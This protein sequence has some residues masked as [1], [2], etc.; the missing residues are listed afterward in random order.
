MD[1]LLN[2]TTNR[3]TDSRAIICRVV[4]NS[5]SRSTFFHLNN[6]ELKN[7]NPLFVDRTLRVT[8]YTNCF[9][10]PSNPEEQCEELILV[11]RTVAVMNNTDITCRSRPR[12]SP[13]MQ[14]VPSSERVTV[15]LRDPGTYMYSV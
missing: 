2:I 3:S 1:G 4:H 13:G 8:Q 12:D 11:F 15:I 5:T 10:P 6:T 9:S 14:Q 7:A